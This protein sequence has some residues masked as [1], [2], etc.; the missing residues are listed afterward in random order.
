MRQFPAS[1]MSFV[2]QDIIQACS[3]LASLEGSFGLA[4]FLIKERWHIA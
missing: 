2:Y 4:R 3:A 1:V